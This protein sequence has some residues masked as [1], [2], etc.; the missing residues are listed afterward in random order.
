MPASRLGFWPSRG[1]YCQRRAA[2]DRACFKSSHRFCPSARP[3]EKSGDLFSS[4]LAHVSQVRCAF[5]GDRAPSW[6]PSR[7]CHP[8]G[9]N[10]TGRGGGGAMGFGIAPKA[11]SAA[12]ATGSGS[13]IASYFLGARARIGRE[14]KAWERSGGGQLCA[15]CS[16]EVDRG[17]ANALYRGARRGWCSHTA[18]SDSACKG[19]A[20]LG[21]ESGQR[22]DHMGPDA[23]HELAKLPPLSDA[24]PPGNS[25][26]DACRPHIDAQACDV[27][28]AE[29][30][31]GEDADD[32]RWSIGGSL[33]SGPMCG[34]R[35]ARRAGP[36]SCFGATSASARECAGVPGC[37]AQAGLNRMSV[38]GG[39][40][41]GRPEV[42]SAGAGRQQGRLRLGLGRSLSFFWHRCSPRVRFTRSR[43]DPAERTG[44]SNIGATVKR[45]N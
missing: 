26:G 29:V 22:L 40:I 32:L 2:N 42:R 28:A 33:G 43:H 6:N 12:K 34:G 4:W 35:V 9:P 36:R 10:C 44:T 24:L 41:H 15:N 19:S 23:G 17:H 13:P 7:A 8:H 5:C 18:T 3:T 39:V 14:A 25:D 37:V 45:R 27:S 11:V 38:K 20:T 1:I 16:Q 30:A 31:A 21:H